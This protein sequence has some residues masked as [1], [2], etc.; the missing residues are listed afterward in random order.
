MDKQA[1]GG[2]GE[3][4]GLTKLISSAVYKLMGHSELEWAVIFPKKSAQ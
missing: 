4:R 2:S 3:A 1:A